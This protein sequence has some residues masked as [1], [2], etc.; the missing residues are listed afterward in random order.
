MAE[1]FN[2]LGEFKIVDGERDLASGGCVRCR[3]PF[4][5][6]TE[7]SAIVCEFASTSILKT[8]ADLHTLD[9]DSG[10]DL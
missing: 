2:P 8:P 7:A 1:V 6:R 4:N 9:E 3:D 10:S 5:E